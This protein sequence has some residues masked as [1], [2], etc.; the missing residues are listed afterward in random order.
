MKLRVEALA[1]L[2]MR[3]CF[4]EFKYEVDIFFD[5]KKLIG[6]ASGKKR[7]HDSDSW[8]IV[9]HQL[10]ECGFEGMGLC[11]SALSKTIT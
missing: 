6:K 4:K 8:N 3:I 1:R 7:F 5:G 11:P 2:W 10:I 9:F